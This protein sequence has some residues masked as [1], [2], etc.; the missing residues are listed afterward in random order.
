MPDPGAPDSKIHNPEASKNI[1]C[2]HVCQKTY[3][4]SKV[5][6]KNVQVA[7][8][9]SFQNRQNSS[10]EPQDLL[11]CATKSPNIAR[12]SPPGAK[13][14]ATSMLNNTFWIPNLTTSALQFT[15]N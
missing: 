6:L 13:L 9:K 14:D 8:P 7:A 2:K 4:C 5:G 1:I 11:P 3:F 15:V 12:W 10:L